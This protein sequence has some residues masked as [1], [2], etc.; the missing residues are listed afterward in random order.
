[1]IATQITRR[2]DN[3]NTNINNNTNTNNN[4]KAIS[5]LKKKKKNFFNYNPF[6]DNHFLHVAYTVENIIV[7]LKNGQIISWGRNVCTLGRKLDKTN[8][9]SYIPGQI[10]ISVKIVDIVAGRCHVLARGS[11]FKVYSWGKNNMGQLGI[12]GF[13]TLSSSETDE[14][15]EIQTFRNIDIKQVFAGGD[16]SFAISKGGNNL[17]G[18]GDNQHNQLG[19]NVESTSKTVAVPKLIDLTDKFLSEVIMYQ[20]KTGNKSY[21]AEC[22]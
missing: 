8:T 13:P 20:T 6:E 14:P 3:I 9:D 16:T 15:S 10:K 21:A 7:L 4:N 18:W 11:N 19:L 1:M 2:E 5:A 12:S 22:N 17:Y